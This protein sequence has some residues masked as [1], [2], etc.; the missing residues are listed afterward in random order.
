MCSL[1]VIQGSM[2]INHLLNHFFHDPKKLIS[3]LLKSY[4][5]Q[6]CLHFPLSPGLGNEK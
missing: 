4:E 1:R 2:E 3:T 6:G 5:R